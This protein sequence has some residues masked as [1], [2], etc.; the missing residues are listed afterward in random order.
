MVIVSRAAGISY[1]W[2]INEIVKLA[3]ERHGI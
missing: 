1:E 3:R 2:L